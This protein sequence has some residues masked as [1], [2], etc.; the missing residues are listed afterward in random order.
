MAAR[1]EAPCPGELSPDPGL[2]G[3]CCGCG[4]HNLSLF[5][6]LIYPVSCLERIDPFWGDSCINE[7]M[8]FPTCADQEE[9]EGERGR[10]S[11]CCGEL[12]GLWKAGGTLT[13]LQGPEWP[14]L[15]GACGPPRWAS[16]ARSFG[17]EPQMNTASASETRWILHGLSGAQAPSCGHVFVTRQGQPG[18]SS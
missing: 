12:R 13:S 2:Q 17:L 3:R 16:P 18:M 11:V 14:E 10:L 6:P 9:D 1:R 8:V 15:A 5:V 4:L 7:P